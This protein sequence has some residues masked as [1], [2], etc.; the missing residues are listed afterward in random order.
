MKAVL[1]V[2]CLAGISTITITACKDSAGS[3]V[4]DA[5]ARGAAQPFWGGHEAG[6]GEEGMRRRS[7][8]AMIAG[9]AL[10]LAGAGA[11]T[12]ATG[13]TAGLGGA[14]TWNQLEKITQAT[15]AR[16]TLTFGGSGNVLLDAWNGG[17]MWSVVKGKFEWDVDRP[18]T[19]AREHVQPVEHHQRRAG[20]VLGMAH[21][22]HRAV[23][24]EPEV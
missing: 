8:L 7:V 20:R 6:K 15:I 24:L 17:P 10:A 14:F 22:E 21:R 23:I 12:I 13:K 16:T 19:A 4:K 5:G 2:L 18:F 3:A 1:R 11:L 9:L